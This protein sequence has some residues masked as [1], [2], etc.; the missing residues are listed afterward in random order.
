MAPTQETR[1]QMI[2]TMPM[3]TPIRIFPIIFLSES[4]H[5]R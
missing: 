2:S 3:T 5:R 4:S 1:S